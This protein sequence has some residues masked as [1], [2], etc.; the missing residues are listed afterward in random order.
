MRLKEDEQT[1]T[2]FCPLHG[3]SCMLLLS[4]LSHNS[5]RASK[6]LNKTEHS[7]TGLSIKSTFYRFISCTQGRSVAGFYPGCQTGTCARTH[8]DSQFRVANLLDRSHTDD[9][10]RMSV[11]TPLG[12]SSDPQVLNSY[13]L[14][15]N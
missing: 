7:Q 6:K 15:L 8:T 12:K 9:P 11:Q 1:H 5:I 14:L 4:S 2:L 13:S 10:C 3:R